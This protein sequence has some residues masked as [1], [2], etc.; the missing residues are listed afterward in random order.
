MPAWGDESACGDAASCHH[1]GV[2]ARASAIPTAL[3]ALGLAASLAAGPAR[4]ETYEAAAEESV[5]VEP[6]LEAAAAEASTE[7]GYRAPERDPGWVRM[8]WDLVFMRPFDLVGLGAGAVFWPIAYPVS[9]VV[10]GSEVV[11]DACLRFPF[12][13]TFRRPLGE[14]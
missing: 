4:A 1:R 14:L 13:R 3:V 5:A 9:R 6:E 10:G 11:Q 8:G 2:H 12:E 7:V